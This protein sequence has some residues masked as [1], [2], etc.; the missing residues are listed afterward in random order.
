MPEVQVNGARYRYSLDGSSGEP[1]VFSHGFLLN[2]H[3]Y[4]ALTGDAAAFIQ[5]LDLAPCHW[6]ATRL[7]SKRPTW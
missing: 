4:D 5:Q 7:Q 2:R 3:Q 6:V 1:V